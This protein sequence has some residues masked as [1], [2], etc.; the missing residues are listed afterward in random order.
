MIFAPGTRHGGTSGT[1]NSV[2]T[3]WKSHPSGVL[4]EPPSL[5]D[6]PTKGCCD[7]T[8]V[9][10]SSCVSL[11]FRKAV[12]D[13]EAAY[14][15]LALLRSWRIA[16]LADDCYTARRIHVFPMLDIQLSR[17]VKDFYALLLRGEWEGH[18]AHPFYKNFFSF[19]IDWSNDFL[20]AY[21]FT[22][23]YTAI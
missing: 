5:P 15:S 17:C 3:S 7:W 1:M 11:P 2:F 18:F 12:P 6:S 16:S 10:L 20:T 13:L 22:P 9:A 19:F 8:E 21:L 4:P 14:F 23:S